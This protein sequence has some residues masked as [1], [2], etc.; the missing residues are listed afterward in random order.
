MIENIRKDVV[1]MI[2][3]PRKK[4]KF[5]SKITQSQAI[6]EMKICLLTSYSITRQQNNSNSSKSKKHIR[7]LIF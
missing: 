4:V 3:I 7:D 1:E 6:N 2:N 5:R